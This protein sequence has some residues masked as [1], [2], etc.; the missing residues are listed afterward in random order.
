MT[1]QYLNAE[2]EEEYLS[3]ITGTSYRLLSYLLLGLHKVLLC[4]IVKH[5]HQKSQHALFFI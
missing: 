5:D 1:S 3:V 2:E 4:F